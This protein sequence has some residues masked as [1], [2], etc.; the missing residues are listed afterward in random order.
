M[1]PPQCSFESSVAHLLRTNALPTPV[2]CAW[3]SEH[4]LVQPRIDL[5][6]VDEE[7]QGLERTLNELKTR[8]AVLATD[9][10][11][12]LALL[13]PVRRLPDD[14]LREIFVSSLP[15]THNAIMAD[16]EAPLLLCHVSS[17]WR[18][19][20]FTT[21][22]LWSSLHVVIRD[23][24]ETTL[25]LAQ[26]WLARAG[27]LPLSLSIAF[28][29][30]LEEMPA[31]YPLLSL[32]LGASKRWKSIKFATPEDQHD[33]FSARI[34]TLSAADVPTLTHVAFA[35]PYSDALFSPLLAA[36]NITSIVSHHIPQ[37]LVAKSSIR[38]NLLTHLELGSAY[39]DYHWTAYEIVEALSRC[40]NLQ[41]CTLVIT[42][43]DPGLI[44]ENEDLSASLPNL[45][46]LT[47]DFQD[48]TIAGLIMQRLRVPELTHLKST[49]PRHAMCLFMSLTSRRPSKLC[50]L[51][52]TGAFART[53]FIQMVG[54]FKTLPTS[55]ESLHIVSKEPAWIGGDV[56]AFTD[57]SLR[58]LDA[59]AL[60][61]LHTLKLEGTP[62]LTDAG[63]L[64]YL[65][66]RAQSGAPLRSL[67]IDFPR[68]VDEDIMPALA[69]LIS[70]G[71]HVE[72]NYG[73]QAMQ[74][75]PY[76]PWEFTDLEDE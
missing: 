53:R 72:L 35:T 67:A 73:E 37:D 41:S 64:S 13:S 28:S 8:R 61:A 2:E 36:P 59:A 38:W 57:E 6:L 23:E 18:S 4:I 31:D 39:Q 11:A 74:G 47:I 12:H 19:I 48:P 30:S 46:S 40:T 22:R 24:G 27:V 43:A 42:A 44:A 7:I 34:A 63:V 71:L 68:E 55:L 29:R 21:P 76:T 65:Y 5:A 16:R 32:F 9:I 54:T 60:P 17:G 1:S 50:H 14:I 58:V 75:E 49:E 20:A 66:A 25:S 45:T 3:I 26:E 52:I 69:G 56:M 51:E 15:S 33:W 62:E 70:G 10:D